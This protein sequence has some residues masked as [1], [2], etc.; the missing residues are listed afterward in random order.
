MSYCEARGRGLR[1]AAG[2]GAVLAV[3]RATGVARVSGGLIRAFGIAGTAV[4]VASIIYWPPISG[5]RYL[6]V[7]DLAAL[8]GAILVI[9]GGAMM[10][11]APMHATAPRSDGR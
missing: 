1:A 8:A 6:G 10:G 7:T 5:Y 3:L 11:P 9:T 4:L 2:V